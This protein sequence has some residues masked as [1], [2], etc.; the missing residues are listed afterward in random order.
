MLLLLPLLVLIPKLDSG[1][2]GSIDHFLENTSKT[3]ESTSKEESKRS[4]AAVKLIN[5]E[6]D[7]QKNIKSKEH[8]LSKYSAVVNQDPNYNFRSA[9]V[10]K[11]FI[12]LI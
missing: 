12:S 7:R 6:E 2:L 5:Y 8:Y 10:S 11:I 1:E 9:R 4:Q 3:K